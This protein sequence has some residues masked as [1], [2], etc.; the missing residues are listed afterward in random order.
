MPLSAAAF[1][2]PVADAQPV[3]FS[4]PGSNVN[5]RE[6]PR[7]NSLEQIAVFSG[8]L[9]GSLPPVS[10][11]AQHIPYEPRTF[12]QGTGASGRLTEAAGSNNAPEQPIA[13]RPDDANA[14]EFVD[15]PMPLP[16]SHSSGPLL[17]AAFEYGGPGYAEDLIS[18]SLETQRLP[19]RRNPDLTDRIT[20]TNLASERAER[21]QVAGRSRRSSAARTPAQGTPVSRQQVSSPAA[22]ASGRADAD[23]P[24]QKMK[25]LK[26]M[27]DAGLIDHDDY[28]AKKADILSRL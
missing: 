26:A 18:G 14:L 25:Q 7:L 5:V 15:G 8:P 4:E 24:V 10:D 12:D 27:L 22:R 13:E 9:S 21:V 28:E 6:M 23:D 16:G 2:A 11:S 20:S 1:Q 19:A 17:E 3:T